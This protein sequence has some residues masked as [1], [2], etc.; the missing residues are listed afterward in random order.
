MQAK[1]IAFMTNFEVLPKKVFLTSDIQ[2]KEWPVFAAAPSAAGDYL[3]VFS[4]R[5]LFSSNPPPPYWE[6]RHAFTVPLMYQVRYVLKTKMSL[7]LRI[8]S[9]WWNSKKNETSDRVCLSFRKSTANKERKNCYIDYTPVAMIILTR[10][11]E[12]A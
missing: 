2:F 4:R 12:A 10:K 1:K 11:E 7:F 6:S 3:F 5:I 8:S 9:C